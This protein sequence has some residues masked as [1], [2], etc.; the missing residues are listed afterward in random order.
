MAV[1]DF[2]D[3]IFNL[4]CERRGTAEIHVIERKFADDISGDLGLALGL[5]IF[6]ERYPKRFLLLKRKDGRVKEVKAIV[7]GRICYF[8]LNGNCKHGH[9]CQQ[10]HICREYLMSNC[11]SQKCQFGFSHDL[12]D[13]NNRKVIESYQ[14]GHVCPSAVKKIIV[15]SFPNSC[16]HYMSR[17]RCPA[18]ERCNF[19]H[20]CDKWARGDCTGTECTLSHDLSPSHVH[21][22][23]VLQ[24]FGLSWSSKIAS[25][26]GLKFLLANIMVSKLPKFSKSDSRS[27]RE[28]KKREARG[29][30]KQ[31]T[32]DDSAACN[33]D[34]ERLEQL[35]EQVALEN[36][37]ESDTESDLIN[38]SS[39]DET[40]ST[41]S[42][43]NTYASSCFDS[44]SDVSIKSEP[45]SYASKSLETITSDEGNFIYFNL[46]VE[47]N[48][49]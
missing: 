19:L 7:Q 47:F 17:R 49:V 20:I 43:V 44:D 38:F 21:N 48:F 41:V 6:L 32:K 8:Y 37:S 30:H 9:K 13:E 12:F 18:G 35:M 11:R 42:E 1:V 34:K 2:A 5:D 15:Q 36:K 23:K 45:C 39:E 22:S 40:M 31:K 3:A 16:K 25:E 46:S 28:T 10:L 14:I 27:S 4:I 33:L 24:R 29:R 26:K